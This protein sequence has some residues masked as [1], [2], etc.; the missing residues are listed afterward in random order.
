MGLAKRLGAVVTFTFLFLGNAGC[1][2]YAPIDPGKYCQSVWNSSSASE[3]ERRQCNPD[4]FTSSPAGIIVPDIVNKRAPIPY[5]PITLD[6]L[7][8]LAAKKKD[9]TYTFTASDI[10]TFEDQ[11]SGKQYGWRDYLIKINAFEQFLNAQGY[12]VRDTSPDPVVLFSTVIPGVTVIPS[13]GPASFTPSRDK[14]FDTSQSSANAPQTRGTTLSF[15]DKKSF[16]GQ[17]I[18][19]RQLAADVSSLNSRAQFSIDGSIVHNDFSLINALAKGSIPRNTTDAYA[20]TA[21]VAVVGQS[22]VNEHN[23]TNGASAAHVDKTLSA[24]LVEKAYPIQ[25]QIGPIPVI[26]HLGFR[27][28]A[29]LNTHASA[30]SQN[31]DAF[32]G[33]TVDA[34]G[35]IDL[36]LGVDVFRVSGGGSV[37]IAK[38]TVGEDSPFTYSHDAVQMCADWSPGYQFKLESLNG[39]FYVEI[40]VWIPVIGTKK[41]RWVIATTPGVV[42]SDETAADSP[43]HGC[44]GANCQGSG[45]EGLLC[46]GTCLDLNSDLANCGACGN[47]C[48][49][50]NACVAGTC[51]PRTISE[52][53][54]TWS[55]V[56]PVP[57]ANCKHISDPAEPT[58]WENTYLCGGISQWS[59]S[60]VPPGQVCTSFANP[61]DAN[62]AAWADDYAC[63]GPT[64]KGGNS[65][66][67]APRDLVFQDP[68]DIARHYL[69]CLKLVVPGNSAWQKAY[70]CW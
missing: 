21:D 61:A 43:Y 8:T 22:I 15:G 48:P 18:L 63:W 23:A 36:G 41:F 46:S 17:V 53:D 25:L 58:G 65:L 33:P 70:L 26:I 66:Q 31:G 34:E 24:N 60:G 6:E 57:N 27:S 20:A 4:F 47:I 44:Y 37:A 10:I 28:T 45:F 2:R 39:Q 29:G 32:L 59:S 14:S 50:G 40:A 12:S 52:G 35:F 69:H 16:W 68:V 30:S 64:A 9:K 54:L 7:R 55:W 56:G 62:P 38:A 13:S 51:Y 67:P 42:L 3:A 5:V 1:P 11:R 49:A 19:Q